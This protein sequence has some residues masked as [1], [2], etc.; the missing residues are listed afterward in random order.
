MLSDLTSPEG[1]S[2]PHSMPKL[3][4]WKAQLS[5][6]S[7]EAQA[8]LSADEYDL[9]SRIYGL[10]QGANLPIRIMAP[11]SRMKTFSSC[12]IRCRRLPPR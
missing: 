3:T 10:D 12:R 4:R 6:D 5:L 8:I 11:A 9:F 1:T 2:S 7:A